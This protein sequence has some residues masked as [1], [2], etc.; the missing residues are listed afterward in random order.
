MLNTNIMQ[1]DLVKPMFAFCAHST[2]LGIHTEASFLYDFNCYYGSRPDYTIELIDLLNWFNDFFCLKLWIKWLVNTVNICKNSLF[3][4]VLR[5]LCVFSK[6]HVYL[7]YIGNVQNI[8]GD[9]SM[10]TSERCKF[11]PRDFA[12][13]SVNNG[14]WRH[15]SQLLDINK[16]ITNY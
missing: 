16:N 15:K 13:R 7:K 2:Y 14:L 11:L 12:S 10:S 4:R 3:V 1:N 9:L 6:T 8:E 5:I